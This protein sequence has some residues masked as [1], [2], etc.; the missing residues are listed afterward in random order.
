MVMGLQCSSSIQQPTSMARDKPLV[1]LTGGTGY[2]GG[3]LL[4]L[5]ERRGLRLRCL[6][7]RPENLRPRMAPATEVVA[8]DVLAPESLPAAFEGGR[9]RLLLDPLDGDF[10]VTIAR[11]RPISRP[12]RSNLGFAG[13]ST[14]SCPR[15]L[16]Q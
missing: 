6:A 15:R 1:L 2:I 7:R 8:G 13:S 16:R 3:R 4:P 9:Y 10:S 11:L 12:P 14:Q 5:L